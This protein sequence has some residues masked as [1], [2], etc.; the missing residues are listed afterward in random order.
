MPLRFW[1]FALIVVALSATGALLALD[2]VPA[3]LVAAILGALGIV[4]ALGLIAFVHQ[5]EAEG[6]R[7][8]PVIAPEPAPL[9]GRGREL[10][11]L[12]PTPI[13]LIEPGGR[14][15]YANRKA[16]EMFPRLTQSQ[17]FANLLR[18]PA[19]VEAVARGFA[20]REVQVADFT[21]FRGQERYYT[22]HVCPVR[23]AADD[24]QAGAM[25]V[26]VQDH[27][28]DRRI[29]QLRTDF[30]A[31]ASH[32]LNTPLASIIGYIE[33]LQGPARDDPPAQARFL[34]IMA[35]QAQRMKRLVEDLLS[36]SQIEMSEHVAPQELCRF[37]DIAREAAASLAPLAK[38][39][40]AELRVCLP[41]SIPQGGDAVRGDRDQLIQ[42][43]VNLLDNAMKYAPDGPVELVSAP[44]DTR[45]PGMIGVTVA[46]R[47]RGIQR[48]HI[49]RLTERFYRVSVQASREQGGTGLGLAIVKHVVN[50]HQGELKVESEIDRG[51]RFTIWLPQVAAAP[52]ESGDQVASDEKA[53]AD[54]SV[55]LS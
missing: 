34:T 6:S 9:S 2:D 17:H 29:E 39:R 40:G 19:F 26:L 35:R 45:H 20:T 30:I 24:L 32:E 16:H 11:E 49:P 7:P 31:N 48:E 54:Q 4:I 27:T 12:L 23:P 42:V 5:P 41:D 53:K 22:A 50:R 8:S 10:L 51:S 15:G 46:D 47:G 33:T 14:I 52:A 21:L 36:L 28:Q 13:F 38:K 43:V 3:P 1:H 55:E 25:L 37:Y 18:A 44:P